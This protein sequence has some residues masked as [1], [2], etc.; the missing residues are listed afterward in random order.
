MDEQAGVDGVHA[1]PDFIRSHF[2]SRSCFAV[3][4]FDNFQ[5]TIADSTFENSIEALQLLLFGSIQPM[6][7]PAASAKRLAGRDYAALCEQ[8]VFVVNAE[9]W[10]TISDHLYM[11]ATQSIDRVSAA[12]FLSYQ[13]QMTE[14]LGILEPK[15][16]QQL[17]TD[18]SYIIM[19]HTF[20][21]NVRE[22]L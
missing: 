11:F 14:S 6:A 17:H 8:V 12:C 3:T 2:K 22:V 4:K 16:L 7:L 10:P 19:T 20:A 13:A 15:A 1:V 18:V 21:Q 9:H 5:E